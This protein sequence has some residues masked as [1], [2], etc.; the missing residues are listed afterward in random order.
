MAYQHPSDN[1]ICIAAL[2]GRDRKREERERNNSVVVIGKCKGNTQTRKK[3][4]DRE[5]ITQTKNILE[6][7]MDVR[8][9]ERGGEGI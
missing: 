7:E 3:M 5:R 8:K 1:T 2:W 6:N 9:T 4:E